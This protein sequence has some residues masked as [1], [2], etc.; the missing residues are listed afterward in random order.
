MFL[1]NLHNFIKYH[2][3][4]IVFLK[5]LYLIFENLAYIWILCEGI[6]NIVDYIINLSNIIMILIDNIL[7]KD[8]Y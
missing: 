1:F 6:I 3:F 5:L 4:I 7:K 2:I 8:N